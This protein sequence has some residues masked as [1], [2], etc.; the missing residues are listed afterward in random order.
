MAAGDWHHFSDGY[1]FRETLFGP[2]V[3]RACAD[4]GGATFATP[5]AEDPRCSGCARAHHG[6]APEGGKRR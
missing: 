1:S 5:E 3:E 6:L 4:C 2:L